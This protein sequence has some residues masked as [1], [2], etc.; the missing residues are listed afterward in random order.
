MASAQKVVHV[1]K[2]SYASYT[3]LSLCYSEDHKPGDWGFKG[4]KSRDMQTRKIYLTE[5]EGQPIPTND[6]WMNLMTEKYS[7]HLWSY[8]Q[9][10]Q[11]NESGLD[12]Q[13][14]S[15]WIED[16]TEL[17]SNTT[18]TVGG[19]DFK[20]ESAVAEHWHDWDV[21][22]SMKQGAKQM[23]VT[24]AHGIPFTWMETKGFAPVLKLNKS[25]WTDTGYTDTDTHYYDSNHKEI[26]TSVETDRLTVE[27]GGD[28]YGVYLPEGSTVT[29]AD[30]NATIE[31][32]DEKKNGY[33]VVAVLNTAD[34][35]NALA[36][37]APC[38][39]RDTRVDWKYTASE[40]RMSTT[41]HIDAD[42]LATGEKADNVMQGFLPH[43]WRDTGYDC[44]LPFDG[45]EYLTPHG[46][47]RTA[48]GNDFEV[49]YRFYGMLPYWAEPSAN[50]SKQN[51]Y[52][53]E[54][55]T[56]MIDD[57][58][59]KGTFGTDTYWG[60]KGL[61]QMALYMMM[62][63]EMGNKELFDKCR[64]R[65]KEAMV[66]WL[67]YTPGEKNGFFAR[68][69]RWGAMVGYSTS[70][71]SDTF[72]D[73][74]FHYGYFTLAGA[75][76]AL[77]DD[78]FRDNYGDMLKLVAKDYANWDRNDNAFP[79]FRTF[80]PWAGHSFAGGMGDG[81]G[82]GQEST[83]EAMQSW[84]GLYLLGV[85]LGDNDM[86]DAGIF[87]WLSEARGTAEYWFDRHKDNIDHEKFKHPYSSNLTCH[88]VGYWTYFGYQNIY[89]QGIQWM[90]TSTAL[91]YLS[92]DKTFANWDY[93][94]LFKD[95]AATAE[96]D[97]SNGRWFDESYTSVSKNDRL[98]NSGDW[99]NVVLSYLQR[100]DPDEAAKVFDQLWDK[101]N[102]IAH[103]SSTNGITY[104]S[105]HS[106]LT[107]GDL[108]WTI[109]GS[110]PTARVYRKADN[111]KVHMAYNPGEETITVRF[112]DGYSM[113]AAP[114][115]LTV[116]GK[117]SR[118]VNDITRE[119]EAV[120]PREELLMPN[121]ALHRPC[122]ESGHENEGCL[123]ENA[124]DGDDGTR[125]GSLHKDGE[126]IMV[127]L[128]QEAKLYKLRI[129]WE[130]AYASLYTVE[131]SDDGK[132]WTYS[133]DVSSDGGWDDIM[134][135]D[136]KA[137]YVRITGKKRST[138]YGISLYEIQAFGCPD[139]A[140]DDDIEGIKIT[141]D[142]DVLKQN[143]PS[144]LSV[145]GYTVGGK[146]VSVDAEFSSDFG[147]VTEDGVFTPKEYGDVTVKVKLP[148]GDDIY[149][150]T[151][152]VEEAIYPRYITISPSKVL[153]TSDG[154]PAKIKIEALDQFK[155][156]IDVADGT[157]NYALTT[158]DYKAVDNT[159]GRYEEKRKS[160]IMNKPGTYKF[161]ALYGEHGD[162][163][164]VD[165]RL[166]TDMNLAYNK[167][168]T[169]STQNG[170][171]GPEKAFDGDATGSRWES[172]WD[173]NEEWL[174]VDL[175]NVYN[176]N[177]VVVYWENA[178]AAEYN[179]QVS[180]DGKTWK[181]VKNVK[182]SPTGGET[183]EFDPENARYVR[184]MGVSKAMPAYGY[185]VYEMEV[186][187]L[188][189]AEMVT[190]DNDANERGFY[191]V[192]GY[193]KS[194]QAI[195]DA[196]SDKGITAYDLTDLKTDGDGYTV[197]PA[198]P[199]ALIYVNGEG[200]SSFSPENDWGAT[201]NVVG[202]NGD[203]EADE[204]VPATSVVYKDGY[205][206]YN[207]YFISAKENRPLTY[208]RVLTANSYAS[209]YL[210][211]ATDIPNGCK[212]YKLV[213]N[214]NQKNVI[215]LVEVNS[216]DANTPY[217]IHTGDKDA[218]LTFTSES[219][220]YIL[221]G[222]GEESTE[223][224][225]VIG[226]ATI[227]G[228]YSYFKGDG[229]QYALSASSET[230]ENGTLKLYKVNGGQIVPFRFYVTLNG[231]TPASAMAFVISNGS[232]GITDINANDAE[233][234]ADIYSIDG[235]MVRKNG[236]SLNGLDK[237][238]YIKNGKKFVK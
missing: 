199:N 26:T 197:T 120:D 35:L 227:Q 156:K 88:G 103:T 28:V 96:R 166:F 220:V 133:Q 155:G 19:K 153:T 94:M 15:Y 192:R 238:V 127:D 65:L 137:R 149:T 139:N 108:D 234:S 66:N 178:R 174:A 95:P 212:A 118:A 228:N 106:H 182:D 128:Q 68:Y 20:P 211:V 163:I 85:A 237:S 224:T 98:D 55:M 62:A 116:E 81:N 104:F 63:R 78:D 209:A 76:L 173:S 117:T 207:N 31:Y 180:V 22:F 97:A 73:H 11:A 216:M 60:G 10:L 148:T 39:P 107:N 195:N 50:D 221:N 114:R 40:G 90:P 138:D 203:S 1:G 49:D 56:K 75:L 47:L 9:M 91:D 175:Q 80:D 72:N 77:V 14:P 52:S 13:H 160:I 183:V 32:A 200:N 196:L 232:T 100:S 86:R 205:A 4:D 169:C 188:G 84:G 189:L 2:G 58:S 18:L 57:Y 30:G 33:V 190:V 67:T 201:Q 176:I 184:I 8:P 154:T 213:G 61:T 167:P 162:T 71:D 150:Q 46:K 110:I 214:A 202:Y 17:K 51:P 45:K 193:A 187:G 48:I 111:S 5:R 129:H 69:D 159:V 230:D 70:F 123:P 119:A 93:E 218:T 135:G 113:E 79:L 16:G 124:T 152:N 222:S 82:N 36:K 157:L 64:K 161:S 134:L 37:Y 112:T 215:S 236:T 7:G 3:P 204:Y 44:K 136:H 6:W 146:T 158:P 141:A 29:I 105:T 43:Q 125:W 140:T 233:K 101:N 122:T 191:K 87:G 208:T 164:D 21:E 168:A 27:R 109:S 170:E 179:L 223:S 131:L 42:N 24:M 53:E 142:R 185:S 54:R 121:L 130:T 34:D 177:K 83:S 206:V 151:F 115:Q 145:V 181:T 25:G 219:N 143:E 171:S 147:D 231:V 102:D 172:K 194:A 198:N 74:H 12:I 186:Y 89:M 165:S 217:I 23:Y 92:E 229:T 126:W 38:V 235:R 210:P 144:Q 41:W 225:T 59:V 99:G 132:T 226:D